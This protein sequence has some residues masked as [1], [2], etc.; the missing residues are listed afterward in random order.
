MKPITLIN[1]ALVQGVATDVLP[2]IWKG[3][4]VVLDIFV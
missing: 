1:E 2:D 3:Q 4:K